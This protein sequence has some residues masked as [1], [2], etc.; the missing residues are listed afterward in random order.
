MNNILELA[1]SRME[2]N[3]QCSADDYIGK[4]G[5]IYCGNC[6]TPRQKYI[7]LLGKNMP[8]LCKCREEELKRQE[9]LDKLIKKQQRIERLKNMSMLGERFKNASFDDVETAHNADVALVRAR[10]I[11]YCSNSFEVLKQGIGI[12][13]FGNKGTGKSLLTACMG[14]ALMQKLH[15]VLYTNFKEIKKQIINS[16]NEFVE[17]L[18][19]VDF[20]FIDDIGKQRVQKNNEDLWLQEE[21]FELINNRY[22]HNMPVIFTSNYSLEELVRDRGFDDATVD[23]IMEMCEIMKITGQS[24]RMTTK[25]ERGKLF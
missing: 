4:D 9:E 22:I 2:V 6:H 12:Y 14:N 13:L 8:M 7:P 1:T 18:S 19:K 11:K 5:L 3:F 21:V 15:T 10:C 23:R 20:L 16:N 17:Q 24:Y 25:N